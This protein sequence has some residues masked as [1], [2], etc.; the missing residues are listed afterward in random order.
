MH[1]SLGRRCLA[2]ILTD[3]MTLR[4]SGFRKV[5]PVF[6]MNSDGMVTCPAIRRR[7]ARSGHVMARLVPSESDREANRRFAPRLKTNGTIIWVLIDHEAR[8]KISI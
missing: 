5:F 1:K 3:S 2:I 7:A 8:C 6:V 4:L